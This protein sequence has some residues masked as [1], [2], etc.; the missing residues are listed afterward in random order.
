MVEAY[1]LVFLQLQ[2]LGVLLTP[3]LII[4]VWFCT[5]KSK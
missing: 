3:V 5:R 1:I 2:L 4:A